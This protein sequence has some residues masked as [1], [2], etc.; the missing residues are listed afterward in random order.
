MT[1]STKTTIMIRP[2]IGLSPT[3]AIQL[4]APCFGS[5]GARRDS[6]TPQRLNPQA[7][8]LNLEERHHV[9]Q[10]TELEELNFR[11]CVD[12]KMQIGRTRHAHSEQL[13]TLGRCSRYHRGRL[14][15]FDGCGQRQNV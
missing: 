2:S 1:I 6:Q 10:T 3:I 4:I 8:K 5:I 14:D 12:C 15:I 9:S 13:E 7:S 11:M